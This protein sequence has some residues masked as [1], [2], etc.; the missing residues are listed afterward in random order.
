MSF[1][2][3]EDILKY[4]YFFLRISSATILLRALR[5]KC[6]SQRQKTFYV[7]LFICCFFILFY[8]IYLF[9]LFFYFIYSF[10][11][12]FFIENKD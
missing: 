6:R 1:T 2:T 8:F 10:I 7:I 3:A 12:V 11:F 4:M 9:L 5:V